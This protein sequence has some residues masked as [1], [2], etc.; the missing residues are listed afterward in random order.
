MKR[1]ILFSVLVLSGLI[2]LAHAESQPSKGAEGIISSDAVNRCFKPKSKYVQQVCTD[3][4]IRYKLSS[5][6][7]EPVG[8]YS[9]SWKLASIDIKNGK[10]YTPQTIPEP[11]KKSVNGLELYIDGSAKVTSFNAPWS[12]TTAHYHRFNTGVA[13]KADK[14]SSY[15][16]PGSP[17]WNKTFIDSKPCSKTEVKYASVADAKY[18]F[19]NGFTLSRLETCSGTEV[20]GVTYIDD[21]I[22]QLCRSEESD[23]YQFCPKKEKKQ[24]EKLEDK[25][26]S[27]PIDDAFA[28]LDDK[29]KKKTNAGNSMDDAFK[30]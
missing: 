21:A 3:Y 17:N 19:I 30:G 7:G 26:Q 16:T 14:G 27:N 15:N 23:K 13:V 2:L 11:L 5:L 20:Y 12:K 9:V 8:N 22:E 28:K 6:M 18:A 24:Q 10:I 29:S 25:K 4:E 1:R